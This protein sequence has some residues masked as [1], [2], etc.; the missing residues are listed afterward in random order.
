MTSA[1]RERQAGFTLTELIIV[2]VIVGIVGTFA[3]TKSV[4]PAVYTLPSQAQTFASD[5]RHA[6]TLA[7]SWGRSLR[8]TIAAGAGGNYSV[9]CVTAAASPCDASPVINP[10]TLSS[11]RVTLQHGV[12]LS[13]PATLDIDSLG[14]P[15][16]SGAYVL[17]ANGVSETVSV[18]AVT[19][20]VS[21]SP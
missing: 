21:V 13:G 2:L 1:L 8:I 11:F 12:A 5:L 17:S 15:S 19:G 20:F 16:T 3:L 4:S 9:S 7:T 6:Q 18:A 10:V 14:Q